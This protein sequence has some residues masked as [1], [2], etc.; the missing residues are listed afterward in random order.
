LEGIFTQTGHAARNRYI[1]QSDTVRERLI[2]DAADT[3]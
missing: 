1:G 2:A 3:V